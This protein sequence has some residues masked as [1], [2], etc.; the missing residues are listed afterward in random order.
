MT[1]RVA[2]HG[3]V[4]PEDDPSP[5]L[6]PAAAH[7]LWPRSPWTRGI[8][9][10]QATWSPTGSLVAVAVSCA[11]VGSQT[12]LGQGQARSAKVLRVRHHVSDAVLRSHAA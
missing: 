10:R 2:M 12:A 9:V 5:L 4:D 11:E 8:Q 7:T 3:W 1:V 6:L